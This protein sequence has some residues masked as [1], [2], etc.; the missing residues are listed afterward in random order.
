VTY[1][2]ARTALYRFVERQLAMIEATPLPADIRNVVA[3]DDLSD[4]ELHGVWLGAGLATQIGLA[5][6]D[7]PERFVRR[8]RTRSPP[9]APRSPPPTGS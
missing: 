2:I 8:R 3:A 7:R 4:D 9:E 6:V 5:L 1:E